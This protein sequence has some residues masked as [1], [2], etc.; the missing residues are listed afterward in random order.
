M[1]AVDPA[2][3]A[4]EDPENHRAKVLVISLHIN[5]D[6]DPSGYGLP[7][8]IKKE[9]DAYLKCGILQ[10]GFLRVRC[11][12]CKDERLVALSECLGLKFRFVFHVRGASRSSQRF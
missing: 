6:Q 4:R 5:A 9:F 3:K 10:Y 7:K 2:R 12:S 8:Y 1:K 11:D